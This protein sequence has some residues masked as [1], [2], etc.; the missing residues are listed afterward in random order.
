MNA[1][2]PTPASSIASGSEGVPCVLGL[3]R[4][5]WDAAERWL[6]VLAARRRR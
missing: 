5:D 6:D 3:A 1:V 4:D 2:A